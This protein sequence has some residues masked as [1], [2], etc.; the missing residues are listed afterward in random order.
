MEQII[1]F[2][3]LDDF[4]FCPISLYYHSYYQDFNDNTYKTTVQTKGTAAHKAVDTQK[5]SSKKSVLQG[6]YVYSDEFKLCGKIDTYYEDEKRLVERKRKVVKIYDGYIFQVYGQYYG[7]KEMGYKVDSI[8]I[9][10][11]LDNK[12]YQIKLPEQ[13]GE[14]LKKFKNTINEIH[15]FSPG[16]YSPTNVS[17]CEACIYSNLCGVKANDEQT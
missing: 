14:M 1:T 7:L 10:S 11:I 8:Q 12:S 2:A 3:E 15:E 13:D 9:Y 4:I 5:Y 6:L 16:N 17:K